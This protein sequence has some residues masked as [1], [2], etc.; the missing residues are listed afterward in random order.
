VSPVAFGYNAELD[1]YAYDP[2]EA[3]ALLEEAGVTGETITLVSSPVFPKGQEVAEVIASYWGA[4]GLEVDLQVLEF[5]QYLDNGLFVDPT[6]PGRPDG[7][8]LQTSTDFQDAARTFAGYIKSDSRGAYRNPDV[9]ALADEAA[10]TAD[11]SVREELYAE[12]LQT[13]CDDAAFVFL[14]PSRDLW[15]TSENLVFTPRP[16]VALI[17]S[18]MALE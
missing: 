7:V 10:S 13:V 5:Q 8:Y 2:D 14:T 4:V 17:F 12:A 3:S 9:D 16:D 6:T 11:S 1:P 18:E 15:G